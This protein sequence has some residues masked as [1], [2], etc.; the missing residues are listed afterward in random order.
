MILK[1]SPKL[2]HGQINIKYVLDSH[3]K[4]KKIWLFA[5]SRSK[6]KWLY[7][8]N[9]YFINNGNIFITN[10]SL[11][12]IGDLGISKSAIESSLDDREIYGIIPY[13][14]PEIFQGQKYTKASDIYSFGMIMWELMTGRRPFWDYVHDTELIIKICDGLH[15]PILTNAP[16]G[17]IKLMQECWNADPKKRPT[18]S[19][20]VKLVHHSS[21]MY[22]N[23]HNHPTW[24]I[25]SPDIGPITINNPDAIY[26]SRPLSAM[27]KSAECTRSLRSQI[28]SVIGK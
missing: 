13:V 12:V 2:F 18:A 24:I 16:E 5:L 6:G 7:V 11:S 22:L 19:D 25:K 8:L 9:I 4:S 26:K 21:K 10:N 23:E 14:A 3:T 20:I 27:I 1:K 17:Y 28:I 15:P